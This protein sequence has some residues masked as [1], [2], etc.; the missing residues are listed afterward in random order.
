MIQSV[1]DWH[2]RTQQQQ[3]FVSLLLSILMMKML[4]C[5]KV[6]EREREREREVYNG[7]LVLFLQCGVILFAKK[8]R[9]F[10]LQKL[11][12]GFD[13]SDAFDDAVA[14]KPKKQNGASTA[15]SKEQAGKQSW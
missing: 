7:C 8:V 1:E 3:P 12:G 9:Q 2:T 10:F 11:V 5:V 15:R 6:R 13:D 14:G 4:D